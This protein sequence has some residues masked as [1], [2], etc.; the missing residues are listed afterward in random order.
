MPRILSFAIVAGLV[1]M[2]AR[3][4]S[5]QT[6]APQASAPKAIAPSDLR[7]Y[8]DDPLAADPT[9]ITVPEPRAR[10]LS[11]ILETVNSAFKNREADSASTFR[12]IRGSRGTPS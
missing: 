8:P 3:Q 9:P 4:I 7:F 6:S 12:R 1:L 2:G 10:A 5:A 11:A